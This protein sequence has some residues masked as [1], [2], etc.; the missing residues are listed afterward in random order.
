MTHFDLF[1]RLHHGERP[2]VLPNA[3]DFSSA[4]A[5]AAAGFPAV[6]TTSLGVSAAAG[7]PDASG[8]ARDETL[9]LARRLVRL[10][11]PISVDIESGFSADPDEVVGLTITLAAMGVAGINLEDGRSDH[12]LAD[13]T[14]QAELIAAI[15]SH[16]PDLFVNA[17]TDTHWLGVD[18]DSTLDRARRYEKAGADGIFVPGLRH[19]DEITELTTA[20]GV[21][22]N[23]LA[24]PDAPTTDDL[25]TLGVRRISTGGLLFRAALATTVD[26]ARAVRDSRP[27]PTGLPSYAEVQSL[28]SG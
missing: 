7:L 24:L 19:R 4:A 15:K 25:T 22:L 12:T 10:P 18:R 5:L 2:L 23:I 16:A 17:R 3:W 21:P 8:L 13:P 20:I 28:I 1:R 27:I 6:A 11:V 26:T 9:A 14:A